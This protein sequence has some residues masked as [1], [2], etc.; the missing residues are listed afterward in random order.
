MAPSLILSCATRAVLG[1]VVAFSLFLLFA[2]HNDPGGGFIGGL[3]A[4]AALVLVYAGDGAGQVERLLPVRPETLLGL[5]LV[6]AV[7][8]AAAGVLAG[9]QVLESGYV[10]V[11]LPLF[12]KVKLASPLVFDAGV[13]LVVVGV[14]GML[15]TTL[16]AREPAVRA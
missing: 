4:G 7:A 10:A 12:D 1:T 2:G 16:G 6:L 15:L 8:T 13:Y 11:H 14:V 5:G 9:G 3:V